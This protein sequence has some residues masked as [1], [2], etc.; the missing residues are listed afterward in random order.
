VTQAS[1]HQCKALQAAA[2]KDHFL[3]VTLQRK[4]Q[5]AISLKPKVVPFAN[6][7]RSVLHCH[8]EAEHERS[9]RRSEG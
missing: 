8:R 9:K 6:A 4:R 2:L 7:K 1:K 5:Q 3:R